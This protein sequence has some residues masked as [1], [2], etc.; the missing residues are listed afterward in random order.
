MPS[1]PRTLVS[2]TP[3]CDANLTVTF[4]KHN[5]KAYNQAGATIRE[6]WRNPGGANNWHF[7]L[8]DAD[9]NTNDDS[10]Y[11]SDD[12]TTS[13]PQAT[14]LYDLPS[15]SALVHLHHASASNSVPSTCFAAIKAG[16]YDT[17]PGLTLR[18]AMKH[19]PSSDAT[20]KCHLKQT[21]QGI[22]ST[23]PKPPPF[24]NCFEILSTLDTPSTEAPSVDP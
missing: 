20:I 23:K 7:P 2:I 8:I 11:P 10:L 9:H 17:F 6:D 14:K 13:S 22:C 4:T 18:N 15:V 16:N 21:R 19:C 12:A 5:V 3:L 24:S 1:F